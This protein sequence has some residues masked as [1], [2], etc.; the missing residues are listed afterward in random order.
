MACFAKFAQSN[1]LH[2]YLPSETLL[3]G[4]QDFS[5]SK[6]H[7]EVCYNP[8]LLIEGCCRLP[9]SGTQVANEGGRFESSNLVAF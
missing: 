4:Q 1:A 6:L 3:L 8:S 7:F 2:E 9:W 5:K